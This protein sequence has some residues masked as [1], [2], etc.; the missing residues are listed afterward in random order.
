MLLGSNG[1]EQVL[2]DQQGVGPSLKLR[3]QLQKNQRQENELDGVP[4]CVHAL[5]E[6]ELPERCCPFGLVSGQSWTSH[7]FCHP[8]TVN[9]IGQLAE[10]VDELERLAEQADESERFVGAIHCPVSDAW[11]SQFRRLPGGGH[12]NTSCGCAADSAECS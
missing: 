5:W 10:L 6:Q 11:R 12:H 7:A 4:G 3:A 9:A 2:G 1:W 8:F